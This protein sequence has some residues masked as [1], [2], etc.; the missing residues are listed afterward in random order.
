MPNDPADPDTPYPAIAP[1]PLPG[2]SPVTDIPEIQCYP[3]NGPAVQPAPPGPPPPGDYEYLVVPRQPPV[4]PNTP[5]YMAF[6]ALQQVEYE[7]AFRRVYADRIDLWDGSRVYRVPVG[8]VWRFDSDING[9]FIGRPPQKQ[10][11][12][13]I[14]DPTIDVMTINDWIPILG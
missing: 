6:T 12:F 13:V 3:D 1:P 2:M 4:A 7:I 5:F 9:A 14:N 11:R 10:F 8:M